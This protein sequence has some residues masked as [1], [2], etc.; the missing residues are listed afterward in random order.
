MYVLFDEEPFVRAATRGQIDVVG[1][2]VKVLGA[3]VNQASANGA[4][5]FER[6]VDGH[7]Q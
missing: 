1:Y 5:L 3:D 7:E 6:A 4:R 2:L